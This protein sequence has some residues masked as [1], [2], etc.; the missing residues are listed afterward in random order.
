MEEP[1]LIKNIL[2][3]PYC[4]GESTKEADIWEPEDLIPLSRRIC[5]DCCCCWDMTH[6]IEYLLTSHMRLD[7]ME[8]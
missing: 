4:G 5:E 1:N 6:P 2:L 3:C 7:K 8:W